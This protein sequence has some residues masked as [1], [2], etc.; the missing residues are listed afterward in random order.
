MNRASKS[1]MCL[2]RNVIA[3]LKT[4]GITVSQPYP[5]NRVLLGLLSQAT[6]ETDPVRIGAILGISGIKARAIDTAGAAK[7]SGKPTPEVSPAQQRERRRNAKADR[8]AFYASDAWRRLRYKAL[9]KYGRK[10]MCCGAS[11]RPAHVDHIKPR[12]IRPDL[13]LDLNNLQILC[14]DCNL[15]KSNLDDTDWRPAA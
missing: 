8:A 10:C 2:R 6:G 7:Y 15:G 14:E 13:E 9:V 3:Y 12:S 11:D 4:K 1:S 5:K